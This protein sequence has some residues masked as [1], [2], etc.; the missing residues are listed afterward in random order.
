MK[1]IIEKKSGEF[2]ENRSQVALTL[3]NTPRSSQ[4]NVII[5][6]KT[7]FM[8]KEISSLPKAVDN[9]QDAIQFKETRMQKNSLKYNSAVLE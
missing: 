1:V 2:E 7:K 5:K 8:S 4:H 6:K 9:N 3:S